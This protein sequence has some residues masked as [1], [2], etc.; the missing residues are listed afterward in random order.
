MSPK[1]LY[2]EEDLNEDVEEEGEDEDDEIIDNDDDGG[3]EEES[4]VVQ[5]SSSIKE[6]QKEENPNKEENIP[7]KTEDNNNKDN[8]NYQP[9][10]LDN[11]TKDDI[12][13]LLLQ[14]PV[15]PENKDENVNDED[16]DEEITI[17]IQEPIKNK[18]SSKVS[19]MVNKNVINE[20]DEQDFDTALTKILSKMVKDPS[21]GIDQ[22]EN[23]IYDILLSDKELIENELNKLHFSK[24][25]DISDKIKTYLEKKEKKLKTIEQKV[26]DEFNKK[27]TFAPVI[28]TGNNTINPNVTQIASK[29]RNLNEFL[30]DQENYQ[31][32]IQEKRATLKDNQEKKAIEELK[33]KPKICQTSKKIVQEKFKGEEVYQ[34]LY[35]K[36][37]TLPKQEKEIKK[38]PSTIN[39]VNK[40]KKQ[41]IYNEAKIREQKIKEKE[42]I[43][44]QKI[45]E[46]ILYK[47]NLNS[48]KYLFKKFKAQY[49]EHIQNIIISSNNT[50]KLTFE[51]VKSL[52]S[53]LNFLSTNHTSQASSEL[54]TKLLNTLFDNLKDENNFIKIDHIFVF[55]LSIL[56]LFEYYII[57]N[58]QNSSQQS[59]ASQNTDVS[60]SAS[61]KTLKT[62]K[63]NTK[64][65]QKNYSVNNVG[66]SKGNGIDE[67]LINKIN[68][69]LSGR[70]TQNK[71][72]GGFDNN[73]NFIITIPQSK[74]IS[75]DFTTFYQN[76]SLKPTVISQTNN[77]TANNS[78]TKQKQ[79]VNT[80][81]SSNKKTHSKSK[82]G[83]HNIGTMNR[84]EQLYQE[85]AKKKNMIEKES[86]KYHQEKVKE[87]LKLCTF[88]PKINTHSS[89]KTNVVP[90]DNSIASQEQRLEML[91]KKGTE[92]LLNKK[93]KTR[94]EIEIEKY[95]SECTFKPETHEVN[96]EIFEKNKSIY[97]DD[98]LMKF[99]QRLK[100][101]RDERE[102]KESAF[103]RGE[104]L[105]KPRGNSEGKSFI[106]KNELTNRRTLS[107]NSSVSQLRGK[108]SFVESIITNTNNGPVVK[109]KVVHKEN[110]VPLLEIDVNLKHGV[111]KKILV[112]DGDTAEELA[113]DFSEEN[114]KFIIFNFI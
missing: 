24:K 48:N 99:H 36:P 72:Y 32:K 104:F 52:Y 60:N 45:K 51:Q 38:N 29:K 10:Q 91:Y 37:Q 68:S 69:E 81:L 55:S 78:A 82:S 75:K 87:E 44:N 79:G 93:D 59:T 20:V 31:K 4:T 40:E 43:E 62:V 94:N 102:Y 70:I 42:T 111:K 53:K 35:T 84:I 8:L 3:F 30:K 7:E 98:D 96:Y 71:K 5:E 108:R 97:Q 13:N 109:K 26:N 57:T 113:T 33:L 50:N 83:N 21:K 65:I 19:K 63:S 56:N 14:S 58:Y 88:K 89:Y 106:K 92:Y 76:Y 18:S 41:N 61:Q 107:N 85:S 67:Q 80:Q 27:C 9:N 2:E 47:T 105:L 6:E 95:K 39:D 77:K 64:I 1:D 86:E 66:L 90:V 112:Y 12:I 114:S 28:N 74:Q 16:K 34:R 25:I 101:G 15:Q 22:N 23:E 49:K 110:E 103:E 73:G 54:E 46:S 17:N 11:Y 100:K